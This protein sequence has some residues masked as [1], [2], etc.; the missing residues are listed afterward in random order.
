ML[1]TVTRGLL[2][3]STLP[4]NAVLVALFRGTLLLKGGVSSKIISDNHFFTRV[5]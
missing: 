2:L 1:D 4:A 5:S 3:R